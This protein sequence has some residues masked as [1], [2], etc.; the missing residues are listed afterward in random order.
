MKKLSVFFTA[1]LFTACVT[2]APPRPMPQYTYNKYPPMTLNVASIQVVDGYNSPLQHPNV[3]HTM[4]DPLPKA[5]NQWARTRFVAGGSEGELTIT[6]K[7]ASVTTQNLPV[8][9]GVQG[10]LNVEQAERFEARVSIEFRAENMGANPNGGGSVNINR[11]QTV[12]ENASVQDRDITLNTMEQTI[13]TD[14]DAGAQT[15]LHDRLP[16]LLQN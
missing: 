13:L 16:F 11:G 10:M 12:P 9:S 8:K 7:N 15:M 6:I 1:L 14:L 2:S 3:E 4:P 5:L